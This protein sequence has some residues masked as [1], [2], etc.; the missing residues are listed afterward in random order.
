MGPVIDVVQST[1]LA[2]DIKVVCAM[3]ID[4]LKQLELELG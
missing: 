3:F 1:A 4:S 2:P